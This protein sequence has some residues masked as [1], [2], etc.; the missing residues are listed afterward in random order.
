MSDE[1][2]I[3][4]FEQC[5]VIELNANKTIVLSAGLKRFLLK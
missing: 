1:D 4:C 5:D 3:Y 2:Q